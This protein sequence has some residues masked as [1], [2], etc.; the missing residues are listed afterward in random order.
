MM[1]HY[2]HSNRKPLPF[3]SILGLEHLD[4]VIEIDQAPIGKHREA[5]RSLISMFYRDQAAIYFGT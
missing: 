3:N 2:Y 4:K 1:Q 5:I